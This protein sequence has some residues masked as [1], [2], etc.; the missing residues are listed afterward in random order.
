MFLPAFFGALTLFATI[1]EL[2]DLFNN[3]WRYLSLEVPVSS[4]AKVMLYFLP[5]AVSNSL[6]IALLFASTYCLATLYADNELT[7]VFGSGVS[8]ARFSIPLFSIALV[9]CGASFAFDDGVVLWTIN[10]KNT[11]SRTLLNQKVSLSKQNVTVISRDGKIVYRAEYYDDASK[12]LSELT[13]VERDDALNPV[14]RTIASTA[15]WDGSKWVLSRVRRF[16][17][18]PDESWNDVSFGTWTGDGIDEPPDAFRSQNRDLAEMS[19]EQLREYAAFLRR[20][21][22]PYAA[23]VAEQH[24]RYSFALTPLVVVLIA[25]AA[26]GRFRK[27][28]LLASLLTSIVLAT[29]YYV[30]RMLTM[31]LAKTGAIDPRAGAWI[32][33][34]IFL[35]AGIVMFKSAKT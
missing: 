32:P 28:V 10:E 26:G 17:K 24:D 18:Q 5:T 34:L 20:A 12:A 1:L 7:I 11:L 22:L 30:A 31:L 35:A 19:V 27:N 8:L 9:L 25:G 4:I 6:P 21:G 23:A 3:L 29:G 16:E 14:A 2:V 33:L 13:I 15:R